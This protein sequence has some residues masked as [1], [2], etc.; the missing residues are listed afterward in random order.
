MVSGTDFPR[1]R[2]EIV[3]SLARHGAATLHEVMGKSGVVNG[4]RPVWPGAEVCGSAI[5][6]SVMTGDNLAIHEALALAQEGDVLVVAVGDASH[7]YWGEITTVA[8]QCRGVVGLVIDGGVA[9]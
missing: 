2:K 9:T 8:A 1:A 6:V 5:T 7:G 4:V 3:E